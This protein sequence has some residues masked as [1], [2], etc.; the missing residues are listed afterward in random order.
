MP[1]SK[2]VSREMMF[3]VWRP[4]HED[5]ERMSRREIQQ[6]YESIFLWYLTDEEDSNPFS[7]FSYDVI[8][9]PTVRRKRTLTFEQLWRRAM[10]YEMIHAAHHA[11]AA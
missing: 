1:Y 4:H 11:G 2:V 7:Y 5:V 9:R 10:R 8:H 6:L 3:N